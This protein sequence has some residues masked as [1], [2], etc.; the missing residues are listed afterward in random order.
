LLGISL[1]L[2]GGYFGGVIDEMVMRVLD[3]MMAFPTILLYLI[4]IAAL[5]AS[6]ANVVI[7]ITLSGAPG[8]A[9]LVRSLTLDI[10]TREYVAAARLRG[11]HPLHIMFVE[12]LPNALGPLIV[13][14]TLRVGYAVFAIGTLGFLGLGLP[15][16][17]PDWGSMVQKAREHVYANPWAVVWPVMAVSS[18]VVALNLVADGLQEELKRY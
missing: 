1:G 5:G 13:D 10:R 15:P 11:E 12:I 3:A 16:P 4:I 9:R 2:I 17:A 18:L 14:A 8:I 6:A 7:A